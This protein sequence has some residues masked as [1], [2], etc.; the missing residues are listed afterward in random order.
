M[1]HL[2]VTA[3]VLV[4]QAPDSI[5]R[6]QLAGAVAAMADSLAGLRGASAQ[7]NRDLD[8]AS[9]ELIV[10]RAGAV[11]QRCVAVRAAATHF[12]SVYARGAEA[13]A[14]DRGMADVRREL[15]NL[16]KEVDRCDR[17]WRVSYRSEEIDSTRAWGP[18]RL[19]RLEASVR[20]Y[21]EAAGRLPYPRPKASAPR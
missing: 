12:D 19:A 21:S 11:R 17:E 2:L 4:S 13:V 10:S 7:F 6:A 20:R 9:P 18:Y 16:E 14:H 5:V 1:V 8:R 3:W 15:R